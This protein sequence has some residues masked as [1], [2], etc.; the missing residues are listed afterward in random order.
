MSKNNGII[1]EKVLFQLSNGRSCEQMVKVI[2]LSQIFHGKKQF[3]WRKAADE[4]RQG[5]TWIDRIF[6]QFLLK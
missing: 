5:K 1:L 4:K 2:R 6:F 3:A